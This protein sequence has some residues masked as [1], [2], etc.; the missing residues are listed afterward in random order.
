MEESRLL[1]PFFI[2]QIEIN[3]I[4]FDSLTDGKNKVYWS[5]GGSMAN[6]YGCGATPLELAH[7]YL[8]KFDNLK[9]EAKTLC[10]ANIH[11]KLAAF[12]WLKK[13]CCARR[14]KKYQRDTDEDWASYYECEYQMIQEFK[15]KLGLEVS[16]DERNNDGPLVKE[17]F[18]HPDVIA[19]IFH[20]PKDVVQDLLLMF[21][22]LDSGLILCPEKFRKYCKNWLHRFHRSPIAWCTLAPTLHFALHHGSEVKKC[23]NFMILTVILS[24]NLIKKLLLCCN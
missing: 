7:E 19:E 9:E 22:M 8:P 13:V 16:K 11:L 6:C 18:K 4:G 10:F 23:Y 3:F 24:P 20:A 5:G 2:E 21:G 14:Y 12:R 17:M 15:E 1:V